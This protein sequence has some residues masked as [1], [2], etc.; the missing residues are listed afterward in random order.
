M[1]SLIQ[2]SEQTHQ[3]ENPTAQEMTSPLQSKM[4]TGC[5]GSGEKVIDEWEVDH[6]HQGHLMDRS[7]SAHKVR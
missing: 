6:W 7:P 1:T 5:W 4:L 2:C 3:N